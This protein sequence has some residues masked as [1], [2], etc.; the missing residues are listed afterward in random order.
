ME[1]ERRD[2]AADADRPRRARPRPRGRWSRCQVQA[3]SPDGETLS[4]FASG[5]PAGLGIDANSGLISGTVAYSDADPNS[6]AYTTTVTVRDDAGHTVSEQF[7][8]TVTDVN[9]AP[10]LGEPAA[11]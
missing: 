9:T 7:P 4:Y 1:R 10:T 11:P 6:G 8:W 3:S 5:L 2:P